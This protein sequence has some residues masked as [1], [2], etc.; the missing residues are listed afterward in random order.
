MNKRA[1]FIY[2]IP[3]IIVSRTLHQVSPP[4]QYAG[5][6]FYKL[7]LVFSDQPPKTLQ[8]FKDKL[9]NPSI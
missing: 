3:G 8:V 9:K 6:E 7:R 1:Q 5:Q 2:K 4:S